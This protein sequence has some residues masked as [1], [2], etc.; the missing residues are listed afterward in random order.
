[1]CKSITLLACRVIVPV[2]R[3]ALVLGNIEGMWKMM[4]QT[5]QSER[6]WFL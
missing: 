5:W 6:R 4:I 3:S 2:T 1:M